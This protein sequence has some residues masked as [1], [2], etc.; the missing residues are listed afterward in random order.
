[1]DY[2]QKTQMT[3]DAHLLYVILNIHAASSDE[4]PTSPAPAP[5]NL[6]GPSSLLGDIVS[7]NLSQYLYRLSDLRS[8]RTNLNESWYSVSEAYRP[9]EEYYSIEVN[10]NGIYSTEDGWPSEGYI[11]LSNSK[12]LLVGWGSV[13]PQ[14]VGYNFTGDSAVIFPSGYLQNVQGDVAASSA[15]RLTSGC[16]LSNL[17]GDLTQINSS[18]AFDATLH[19]FDYPTSASSGM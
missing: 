19:G 2:I 11:E 12:R 18:W 7:G 13:D 14:M 16:F 1:V 9:V 4:S 17:T 10:E 3:L 5:T 15:G 6:P 8:E